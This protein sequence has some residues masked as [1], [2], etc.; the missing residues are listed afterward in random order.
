MREGKHPYAEYYDEASKAI[1][2][3]R[4]H[5]DIRLFGYKF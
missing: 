5:N 2:A 3:G 1:V 4:H